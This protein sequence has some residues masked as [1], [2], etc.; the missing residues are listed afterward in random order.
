MARRCWNFSRISATD[1]TTCGADAVH[2]EVGVALQQGHH[3][4]E[5]AEDLALGGGLHDLDE[6][7][8]L[9]ALLALGA[10]A[11]EG[12]GGLADAL[13]DGH[14]VDLGLSEERLDF[15]LEVVA[16][17]GHG[18]ELGAVGL[19]VQADP[20]P[21]VVRVRRRV[22]AP[23]ARCSARPGAACRR[24]R[25]RGPAGRSR[26]AGAKVSY[27]PRTRED[28]KDSSMPSSTPVTLPPTAPST[29]PPGVLPRRSC[30][31]SSSGLRS[32]AE[33]GDVRP[34]PA[35]AVDDEDGGVVRR[36]SPPIRVKPRTCSSEALACRR[37]SATTALR[38]VAAHLWA[39]PYEPGR[40]R[41]RE[42][43]VD[44]LRTT[45]A[46]HAVNRT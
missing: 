19:L 21:E 13:Q 35:R 8:A 34:D 25:D 4:G 30:I 23:R 41:H 36:S 26:V 38:L 2:H 27:W 14:G 5:P 43:P 6:G 46:R 17:P 28:R 42:I 20:E 40:G 29:A 37:S 1:G 7:A 9:V 32:L 11:G 45:D 24:R 18:R 10:A 22:R 15:A 31:L 16:Q 39:R 33:P 12:L 3:G 44:H